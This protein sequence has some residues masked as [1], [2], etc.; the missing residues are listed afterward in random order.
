MDCEPGREN[1]I[2][3]L[4]IAE[5]Q[6][7]AVSGVP[8]SLGHVPKVERVRLVGQVS[9]HTEPGK[10]QG[11]A[12]NEQPYKAGGQ[13]VAPR[14]SIDGRQLQVLPAGRVP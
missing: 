1:A 8:G 11:E 7:S 12:E 13:S 3:D 10:R 4:H 5:N 2:S 9:R 6:G 14:D